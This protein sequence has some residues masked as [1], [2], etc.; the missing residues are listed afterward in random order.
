[1]KN[2]KKIDEATHDTE[3]DRLAVILIV[4]TLIQLGMLTLV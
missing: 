1:M 4:F 2:E 3:M